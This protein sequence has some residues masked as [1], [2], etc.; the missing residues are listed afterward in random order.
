LNPYV[1]VNS[2]CS[3]CT[4]SN[5]VS[6]SSTVSA[7]SCKSSF[8]L[9]N[10]YCNKC[11]LNC[12]TCSSAYDCSACASGFYLNTSIVTCNTCPLG[13]KTCNQYTPTTCT[14]CNN[15]YLLSNFNCSIINCTFTNCQY[16]SSASVCQQCSLFYYWNGSQCV[17]GGSISCE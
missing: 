10:S 14:S 1:L 15:G 11:L 8:Y 3:L 4:I 16:C 5:A 17:I 6:C 13:C 12:A 7:L 2:S 9:S